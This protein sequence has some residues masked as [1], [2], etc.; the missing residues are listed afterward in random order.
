VRQNARGM[1][2]KRRDAVVIESVVTESQDA[3]AVQ[4]IDLPQCRR[5]R[6][7]E[8]DQKHGRTAP[9]TSRGRQSLDPIA[10]RTSVNPAERGLIR[11]MRIEWV[12]AVGEAMANARVLRR[13]IAAPMFKL[14]I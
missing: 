2:S 8:C 6:Q 1:I 7:R 5:I 9:R 13:P 14:P 4:A 11:L 3:V 12:A 10:G